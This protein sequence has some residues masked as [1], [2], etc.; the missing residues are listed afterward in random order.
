VKRRLLIESSSGLV[1]FRDA[2]VE[3]PATREDDARRSLRSGEH[4]GSWFFIDADDAV[5][6]R[7]DLFIGEQPSGLPAHRFRSLGGSFLLQVPSG[8]LS[9]SGLESWSNRAAVETIDVEPGPHALSVL[10]GEAFDGPA[11]DREMR[12][13]I[14]EAD[15]NYRTRVDRIGLAGCLS[16]IFAAVIF[17]LPAT[18]DLWPLALSVLAV[19]WLPFLILQRLPRYRD[20]ERRVREREQSLPHYVVQLDRT[21]TTDSLVGG[22][23]NVG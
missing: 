9:V 7:L 10:G 8:R 13:I 23:L 20:I 6:F 14:G 22:H 16:T 11:Y 2:S 3:A 4:D 1:V 12:Q 15:W 5:A 18:R 17:A 19:G 21:A